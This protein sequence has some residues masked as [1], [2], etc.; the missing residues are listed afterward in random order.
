MESEIS[1]FLKRDHDQLNGVFR[2]FQKGKE[3]KDFVKARGY[4]IR[5]KHG[6][7]RHMELEEQV[8]FTFYE[9]RSGKAE[10]GLTSVIRQEHN[11]L[12]QIIHIIH[13]K[14]LEDNF[15][16]DEEEKEFILILESHHI[17]EEESLYPAID[18]VTTEEEKKEIF[19]RL[20]NYPKERCRACFED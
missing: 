11:R 9:E 20:K 4:F 1:K 17:K 7:L 12:R 15:E 6:L 8:L 18:I 13:G 14:I 16:I 3:E 2:E 10:M 5:F 19:S